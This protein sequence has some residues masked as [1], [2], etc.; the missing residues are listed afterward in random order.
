M[1][2][3]HQER[4]ALGIGNHLL[5]D[6]SSLHRLEVHTVGLHCS[7]IF[8]LI[9]RIP[10][11]RS[12][13]TQLKCLCHRVQ[14][15]NAIEIH[16]SIVCHIIEILPLAIGWLPYKLLRFHLHLTR[17]IKQV[18]RTHQFFH[19]SILQRS[20]YYLFY[21]FVHLLYQFTADGRKYTIRNEI[22]L[23]ALQGNT[24]ALI[25]RG[26]QLAELRSDVI[27]LRALRLLQRHLIEHLAQFSGNGSNRRKI[28]RLEI[29][30]SHHCL[31]CNQDTGRLVLRRILIDAL[32]IQDY[33]N[34]ATGSLPGKNILESLV[35]VAIQCH[36]R[37]QVLWHAKREEAVAFH[38]IHTEALQFAFVIDEAEAIAIGKAG[39]SGNIERLGTTNLLHL[40]HK[41]THCLRCIK[42]CDVGLSA[43]EKIIGI[44][45][46]EGFL[47]IWLEIVSRFTHGCSDVF[48]IAGSH[49]LIKFLTIGSHH[50]LHVVYILQSTFNLKRADACIG[51][52]LHV[53]YLAEILERKQ[54]T[55]MF[56]L[57]II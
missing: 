46:V 39:N 31:G 12:F 28:C 35:V 34:L 1:A 3:L 11:Q 26:A 41:L 2:T 56:N 21:L 38:S 23:Y 19:E 29:W 30:S 32:H 54:M 8:F 22:F 33:R 50:V 20:I 47:Q 57:L 53:V 9:F 40:A 42:R 49:Y 13:H 43:I 27:T 18:R 7:L 25:A 45:T 24:L 17:K 5:V 15:V 55:L 51:K 4:L 10:F 6:T 44:S 48:A 36:A 14:T 37:T 52:I 16:R